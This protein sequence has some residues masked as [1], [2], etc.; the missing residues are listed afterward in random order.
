MVTL[1]LTMSLLLLDPIVQL[2]PLLGETPPV[3]PSSPPL[4]L[5][6]GGGV[7]AAEASTP[8]PPFD[9]AVPLLSRGEAEPLAPAGDHGV[10]V[11]Q[12]GRR[13]VGAERD[14]KSSSSSR[15]R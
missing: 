14:S 11:G 12:W 10:V 4:R 13:C 6:W 1:S 7:L 15:S 5:P 3:W 9:T 8:P 2:L